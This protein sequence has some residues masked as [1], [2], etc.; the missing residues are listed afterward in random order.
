MAHLTAHRED[1]AL[2]RWLFLGGL[3]YMVLL[4]VFWTFLAAAARADRVTLDPPPAGRP[5]PVCASGDVYVDT[6]EMCLCTSCRAVYA[7]ASP[8]EA[9]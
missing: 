7:L 9:S 6:D 4:V 3:V 5:C 2:M 8:S 1:G